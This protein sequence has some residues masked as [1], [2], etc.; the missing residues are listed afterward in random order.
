MDEALGREKVYT[1]RWK[2]SLYL[3]TSITIKKSENFS[4]HS[5]T[6]NIPHYFAF[7]WIWLNLL[8]SLIIASH[9]CFLSDSL[10]YLPSHSSLKSISWWKFP[11][12]S[13]ICC[14]L[15]TVSTKLFCICSYY[16]LVHEIPCWLYSIGLVQLNYHVYHTCK[17]ISQS[18]TEITRIWFS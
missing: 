8:V 4:Q 1:H 9:G 5:S 3:S 18:K 13:S 10:Q 7:F 15:S 16:L 6:V 11:F 17:T 14:S 12:N 2:Y